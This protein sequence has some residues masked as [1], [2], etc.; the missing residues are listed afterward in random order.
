[1]KNGTGCYSYSNGAV[2]KGEFKNDNRNGQG[3][4]YY[5]NGN[6]SVDGTWVDNKLNGIAYLKLKN[7][8]YD[9]S[10]KDGFKQGKGKMIKENGDRY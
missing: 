5:R 6:G 3:I 4:Y 2:Y 7:C 10:F 1:M 9:G 8:T